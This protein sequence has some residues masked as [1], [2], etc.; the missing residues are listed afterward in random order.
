MQNIVARQSL[1]SPWN[2][3]ILSSALDSRSQQRD[4]E[5]MKFLSA[6][7]VLLLAIGLMNAENIEQEDG[8]LLVTKNI[9]NNYVVE[10]L[11]ITVKYTIYN[12]GNQ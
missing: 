10:G 9:H 8:K 4:K 3:Y 2:P 1:R 11:D 12:A 7:C 6:I 5:K